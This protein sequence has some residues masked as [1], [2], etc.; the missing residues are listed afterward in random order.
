MDYCM[1]EGFN[2]TPCP[3]PTQARLGEL[4]TQ[5]CPYPLADMDGRGDGVATV[6]QA[7]R[8]PWGEGQGEGRFPPFKAPAG[9]A[10]TLGNLV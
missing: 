8:L 3:S 10:E 5:E 4:A 9:S 7:S 1:I 2:P 6:V